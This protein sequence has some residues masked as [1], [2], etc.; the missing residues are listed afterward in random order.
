M[1]ESKG[2]FASREPKETAS[3]LMNRAKS[4][5]NRL[6]SNQHLDKIRNMWRAYHGFYSSNNH[7]ISF[8]GEQ[9]ELVDVPVNHF[10]NIGEHIVRMITSNRPTMDARAINTDY[11]SLAQTHLANGIL[12]Y[13]M[14]E[15]NLEDAIMRACEM[16]VVL[17]TGYI[18]MDWNATAGDEYDIDPDTGELSYT[19]ELEFSNPSFLDV[20]VDGTKESW[21]NDW[22]LVRSF[23]NKYN[24]SAKYPEYADKIEGLATK[25][26]ESIKTLSLFS[27]DETEDV[28]VYE[29]YHK[30]TEAMPEGRYLLFLDSDIVLLDTPIPYK[31]IPVY[32][33][34][35]AE[36]LGTPYGYTP[37]FDVYPIQ[38]AVNAAYSTIIT[39]QNAFGVQN[40]Y[41]PRGAD[42][43]VQSIEGG[44]NIIE[45]NAKPEPLNLTN[46]PT[47]IFSMLQRMIGDMETLSG[48][49]SVTRGNPEAS[50]KSG[51]A[52]ALVQSMSLQFISGLQRSYVKAIEDVGT[53]LL[54]ILKDYA[55]TPKLVALVGR[56]NRPLLKEFTGDM[57]DSINRVIVDMG[58]PLSKTIAGRVQMAEQLAQMNLLKNPEQYFQIMNTGRLDSAYEGEISQ[59]MCIKQENEEFLEGKRPKAIFLDKH[60]M[61]IQEH[62]TV[63][64]DPE[65]RKNPELV[66]IVATHIQEHI[67]FLRNTNPDV[68]KMIGEQPLNP[69]QNADSSTMPPGPM[70]ASSTEGSPAGDIL[71][72]EQMAKMGQVVSGNQVAQLP[73][74][75][76]PPA[77]FE[78]LPTDPA[79]LIY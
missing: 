59:L 57:I 62:S 53:G 39:N 76:T 75:A 55:H 29:F 33:I 79:E 30:K 36:I 42:I 34:V 48:V 49:S 63:I 14:R 38:E 17:G 28:P 21:D 69:Q 35:P 73:Q 51:A 23:E 27:N 70:S 71:T 3:V 66:A 43:N 9:G 45:G 58:N 67:D 5:F 61:H 1:A 65:L 41:V 7:Q 4:F 32:R 13:Y 44:L 46:T 50:L 20:V 37:L 60:A 6:E 19:G 22:V 72:P 26:D 10:R 40:V 52:L 8:T 56:H 15:K 68:L 16:S 54:S 11:K 31:E 25:S 18:K 64:A 47:E 12:D 77:P 24:L 2:Y 78:Q 74:P